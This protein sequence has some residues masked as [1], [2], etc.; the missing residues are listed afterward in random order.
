MNKMNRKYLKNGIEIKLG[1]DTFKIVNLVGK[2]ANCVVYEVIKKKN[3][4]EYKYYLKECYPYNVDITRNA[5]GS[6]KWADEDV[7]EKSLKNFENAYRTLLKIYANEY[8]TNSTSIPVEIYEGNDTIYILND[9]KIGSTF[10]DDNTKNLSDILATI[11][12]YKKVIE[13]G[14]GIAQLFSF[15]LYMEG[16]TPYVFLKLLIK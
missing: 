5:D 1:N 15:F 13:G 11:I 3:D 7:K 10:K 16:D 8:F 14:I 2:G 9:I 4:Y 6:L 12:A